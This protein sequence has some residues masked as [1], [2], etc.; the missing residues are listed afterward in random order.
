MKKKVMGILATLFFTLV[1]IVFVAPIFIVLIN[2][3]KSKT[4]INL[5]TFKLPTEESYVGLENYKTAITQYDFLKAV[6]WTLFITVF[7]VAVIL[8]CC[9]MTAWFITRVKNVF[10][11]MIYL[12]CVFSMVIPFQ[13]V[14]FTLSGTADSLHLNTPWGIV[15]VYLGFG[16]GLAV[17]MFTGFVKSIPVE[18]EEAAMID[19]CS[20]LRTFFCVVVPMMKPTFISVGILEAMW[21]WND[22]LL[23]YLVLDIKEFKTIS[24]VIQY[25]KG[26]Y[27][28]VDM[29]AIMACLIMA[30]IPV[31]VFYLCAQKYIVKGVA[32][33]AVKG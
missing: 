6:G 10:T 21:I 24:I 32:A 9:S 3:M 25:M 13:M 31:V 4:F 15:I 33:G 14:M 12:L 17:F 30:I 28:R 22:F 18:V 29:G 19:G 23:P 11:K 16:A 7:S 8:I 5:E 2:S 1:S 27:G 26:S 20:P